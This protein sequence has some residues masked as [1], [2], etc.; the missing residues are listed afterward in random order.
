MI[1]GKQTDNGQVRM[2]VV[3]PRMAHVQGT[4]AATR[5]FP[6]PMSLLQPRVASAWEIL[7][8]SVFMSYFYVTVGWLSNKILLIGI[9]VEFY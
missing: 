5:R 9:D 8:V 3:E 2:D 7:L 6:E 1:P 4:L